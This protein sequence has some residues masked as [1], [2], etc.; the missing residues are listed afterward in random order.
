MLGTEG[1]ID[2]D[3]QHCQ[4]VVYRGV[5]CLDF[6]SR[7]IPRTK[8]SAMLGVGR[9]LVLSTQIYILVNLDNRQ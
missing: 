4:G 7:D 2:P 1:V 5:P 6:A 9:S 8:R 3:D